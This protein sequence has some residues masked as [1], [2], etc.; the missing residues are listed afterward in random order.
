MS[1]GPEE[2]AAYKNLIQD[3]QRQVRKTLPDSP[4]EVIGSHRTGLATSTSDLDFRLSL[5]EFE[6]PFDK[7]GPSSTRPKAKRA[8]IRQLK[9]LSK[10]FASLGEFHQMEIR[11]GRTPIISCFHFP[12]QLNIQIQALRENT[13]SRE[14][15]LNYLAEFPTLRPLYILIK[16]MLEMRDL[17]DVHLGGLGAYSIFM[18]VVAALKNSEGSLAPDD[19]SRQ[20]LS[21]LKLYS[22]IDMH[23]YGISVDPFELFPKT[24]DKPSQVL[25]QATFDD[26]ILRGRRQIAKVKESKPF[27]LCL[28]DPANPFNDLGS[29]AHEIER[30]QAIFRTAKSDLERR[31]EVFERLPFPKATKS[32][33]SREAM[34]DTLVGGNYRWF[35]SRRARVKNWAWRVLP[36]K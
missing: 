27:L 10:D 16:T 36:D 33:W 29:K 9:S 19:I 14:Y 18:M 4:I 7:P 6:K 21:F 12:T 28:Q 24:N 17:R 22:E 1:P 31:I 15:V 25:S 11:Y 20:L 13:A 32:R 3:V 35:Q 8:S 5:P 23:R 30:I 34:L 2:S 26:P